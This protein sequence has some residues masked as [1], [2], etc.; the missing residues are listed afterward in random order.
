[1]QSIKDA[2]QMGSEKKRR[3]R[4]NKTN[5]AHTQRSIP[6]RKTESLPLESLASVLD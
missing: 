3:R 1:M 6:C 5:F 4:T 2:Q